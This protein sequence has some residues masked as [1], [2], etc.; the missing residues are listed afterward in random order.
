MELFNL[1]VSTKV[2]RVVP[3]NTFD[4]Y[5]TTKQ[6]KQF[7]DW[8]SRIIWTNKLSIDTV[9]L[10]GKE[11]LEIQ[12][13][14]VELKAREDI[15]ALLDVIDRAIPYHIVFVLKHAGQVSLVTSAKH[16]HPVNEDK[17]VIDWTFRSEWMKPEECRYLFRLKK[18]LDDIHHDFCRQ[19]A[20]RAESERMPM[21]EVIAHQK[22]V[23]GLEKEIEQLKSA[24]ARS[25]QFNQKVELNLRLK[26][27]E[28]ELGGLIS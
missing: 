17:A 9:N 3:K 27:V 16:P 5:T 14:T 23:A 25:K 6:K 13:F 19:L 18:S 28:K 22:Q 11:I 24:I 7:V 20:G 8:I 15:Q 21:Q 12:L 10:E 2:G 1:P 26:D 4:A